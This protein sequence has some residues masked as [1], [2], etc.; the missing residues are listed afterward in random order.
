MRSGFITLA[1][2]AIVLG[3]VTWAFPPPRAP[4]PATHADAPQRSEQPGTAQGRKAPRNAPVATEVDLGEYE[5]RAA[6]HERVRTFFAQ[7][8]L[9]TSEQKRQTA[10]ELDQQVAE[11]ERRHE[12][13]AAESLTLRLA[14]IRESAPESEQLE[15]M[16]ALR[17]QY[18]ARNEQLGAQ[19]P[20]PM[21]E[22]YKAR[23]Q[24]IVEH[25]A[26]LREIPDGLTR[27][28]YLRERLQRER[29]ALLEPGVED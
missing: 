8:P 4:S 20:D 10:A 28:E 25:V 17:D 21:F 3:V 2:V 22:L 29:E 16:Q 18:R 11:Y 24:E 9:L 14:L 7:A 19:A 26:A 23:E 12:L 5:A 13:S 6:F 15:R 1:I 27:E